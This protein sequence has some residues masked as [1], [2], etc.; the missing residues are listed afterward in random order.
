MFSSEEQWTSFL[1]IYKYKIKVTCLYNNLISIKYNSFSCCVT[2]LNEAIEHAFK[3]CWKDLYKE[4]N[5]PH[6]IDNP[7]Q[8]SKLCRLFDVTE[9]INDEVPDHAKKKN[10]DKNPGIS[11]LLVLTKAREKLL[12]TCRMKWYLDHAFKIAAV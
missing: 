3:V 5:K 12:Y 10:S 4:I 2:V 9:V 7:K 1:F 6:D 8:Y 11:K